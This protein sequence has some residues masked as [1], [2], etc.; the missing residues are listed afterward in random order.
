MMLLL[1]LLGFFFFFKQKT[2]YEIT[3]GDWSSDVCS[4]DL[5][6]PRQHQRLV[7]QRAAGRRSF[8][9]GLRGRAPDRPG[10]D[11]AGARNHVTNATGAVRRT[12]PTVAPRLLGPIRPRPR[13]L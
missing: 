2:A 1:S 6:G 7:H 4:S 12:R 10:P 11:A 9:D 5:R 3:T 13:W 8:T